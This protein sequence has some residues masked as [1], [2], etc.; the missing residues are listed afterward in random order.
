[1]L[2]TKPTSHFNPLNVRN[3]IFVNVIIQENEQPDF[4]YVSELRPKQDELQLKKIFW[5]VKLKVKRNIRW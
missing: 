4:L 3:V 5:R 2:T 1:M